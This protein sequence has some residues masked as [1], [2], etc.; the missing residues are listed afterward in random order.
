MTAA[1]VCDGCGQILS[2]R[3]NTGGDSP[4][5]I[6]VSFGRWPAGP[7]DLPPVNF[8]LSIDPDG[9]DTDS[10]VAV[11]EHTYDPEVHL[12]SAECL[13]TWAAGYAR[14]VDL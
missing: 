6:V 7:F 12:C 14:T 11:T 4:G 8:D 1:F 5:W 13:A 3:P 2:T 10:T 9:S